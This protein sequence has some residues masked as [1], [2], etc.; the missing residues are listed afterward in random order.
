MRNKSI[1]FI[2]ATFFLSLSLWNAFGTKQDFSESERRKLENFPEVSMENILSGKFAEDFEDYMVDHFPERDSWRRIKVY[3][4]TEVFAQKDNNGLYQADGHLSK[5]EYPMN[6]QMIDHAVQVFRNV[7]ETYLDDNNVYVAV[8]PDKNR[9]LASE[10]GYLSMDYDKF[11]EYV[12]IKLND[13]TYVE[14]ADELELSDYYKTDSHWRQE[15]IVDVAKKLGQ[16]MGADVSGEYE[17]K[18]LEQP[19]YGV[20]VGQ[21]ALKCEPDTI[22][23]LENDTIRQLTVEGADAIYD[24]KK[25]DGRE[26]YEFFLSGNQPIITITNENA[27]EGRRLI[28]FRDSFG[29]SL[30]PLLCEGYEEVVLVD[31]RYIS[32]DLLGDYVNFENADVLFLHSTMLLNQ[33]LAIK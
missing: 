31:L 25:A 33:S 29:S 11:S 17:L 7:Q 26:P 8:I 16:T 28:M 4:K 27:A 30:A 10:N 20:Y 5:I 22:R 18:E 21:S 14:I 3:A 6:K 23:Y 12:R 19:F 9:F 32:S 13:M 1:V 15:G 2:T 24:M